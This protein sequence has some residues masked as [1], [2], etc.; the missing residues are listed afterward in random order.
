MN[1]LLRTMRSM[2]EPGGLTALDAPGAAEWKR[3]VGECLENALTRT[4]GS[5]FKSSDAAMNHL[6][7][8]DWAGLPA[9]VTTCIGRANALSLL[10]WEGDDR[11]MPRGRALQEEYI[12]W[13][14]VRD[15]DG[16]VQRIELTTEL[17]D[18][19]RVL[20][21]YEPSRLLDL[22]AELAGEASVNPSAAYGS[23]DP[24][25]RDVTPD[26]R[27]WAFALTML[28][29]AGRS[30]YNSGR[31]ALCCMGQRMNSLESIVRLAVEGACRRVVRDPCDGRLRCPTSSEVIP[32]LREAAALGRG[33]D[34]IIVERLTRLAF[35]GRLVAFDDPLGIYIQSVQRTRLRTPGGEIVPPEWLTFSRGRSP[36]VSHDGRPR[37]QRLSVEVPPSERYSLGDVIDVATEQ[38]IRHGGQVAD[39]VQ[40]AV[41]FRASD[42]TESVDEPTSISATDGHMSCEDIRD[43]HERFVESRVHA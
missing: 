5:R 13:R 14:V 20:A 33:S 22:L 29:P 24:F 39:L 37:Y 43:Q 42:P 8:C 1:S 32:L 6:A 40:L 2:R 11:A 28:P 34:P 30:P 10:D 9:R 4:A 15:A 36:E 35:E 16:I 23:L 41:F 3:R 26:E 17:P 38:P 27:E 31:R 19:W 12:E 18:Y 21:A 7:M 25:A